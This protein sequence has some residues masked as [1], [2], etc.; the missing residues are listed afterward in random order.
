M[1]LVESARQALVGAYDGKNWYGPPLAKILEGIGHEEAARKAADGGPSIWDLVL[2]ITGWISEA[3]KGLTAEPL[4]DPGEWD[5]K[6]VTDTS[7]AAWAGALAN[8]E[9]AHRDL[10]E[11][12]EDFP[13][14]RLAETVCAGPD[15]PL[16][17]TFEMLILGI[18]Q[19]NVYH[20]G[21]IAL[22]KRLG[23]APQDR[24]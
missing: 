8:L 10:L 23:E 14:S 4:A 18:L 24:P 21:Q 19:H 13:D 12:L 11:A 2:H 6:G 9:R 22:T 15:L 5:W 20:A 17:F 7:E 16:G 3:I 1:D